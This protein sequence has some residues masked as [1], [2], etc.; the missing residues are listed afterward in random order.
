MA[1]QYSRIGLYH[2]PPTT[3]TSP[4]R[5]RPTLRV[6]CSFMPRLLR[7]HGLKECRSPR[8]SRGSQR[9]TRAQPL[10]S[11]LSL[12]LTSTASSRFCG[13]VR[14]ET[15]LLH[16]Q[17]ILNGE[18]FNAEGCTTAAR[19]CGEWTKVND[20]RTTGDH[21]YIRCT[22]RE[23]SNRVCHRSKS[24]NIGSILVLVSLEEIQ[25]PA[26]NVLQDAEMSRRQ[27]PHLFSPASR[28]TLLPLSF[29]RVYVRICCAA[30]LL[31]NFRCLLSV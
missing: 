22:V 17:A 1:I 24:G 18:T 4:Y 23:V 31:P 29:S 16:Q 12:F 3:T 27:F 20:L 5:F 8:T 19:V 26:C 25:Q 14:T 6:N 9:T 21:L 30:I 11:T 2:P 13:V 28:H 7:L 15:C 10:G